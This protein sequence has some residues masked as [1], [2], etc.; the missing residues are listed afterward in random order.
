MKIFSVCGISTTGK[1]TTIECLIRELCKRG[2]R[3]GSVKE[4][5]YEQFEIDPSPTSNTHRH[6]AAGAALVT[7]RGYRETDILFPEML[8]MKKILEFYEGNFDYVVLEGVDDIP[9][10]T[11]VTAR[12]AADFKDK[13]S[14]Y[15]FCISGRIGDD[16]G[17]GLPYLDATT[18]IGKLTDLVERVVYDQLPNV[19]ED[20]CT[21][22]G[23]SCAT[24]GAK[25]LR[26][27]RSRSDCVAQRGVTLS[28]DGNPIPIVPFVQ[29][30]LRG[31]ILGIVRELDGYREGG[32][33]IIRF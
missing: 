11:I 10:P 20:C 5:H 27:E 30:I 21:A 15:T 23:E 25:I 22:C 7:A 6:R 24:L 2:Y 31:S 33:I 1:T 4:I 17:T 12:T 13:L 3:V 26:G 18:D 16:G 8:P 19:S 32:E 9:V 29:N 14:D 28:V